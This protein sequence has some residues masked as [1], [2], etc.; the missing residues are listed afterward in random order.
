VLAGFRVRQDRRGMR[1]RCCAFSTVVFTVVVRGVVRL[2][3]SFA[4][5]VLFPGGRQEGSGEP[6]TGAVVFLGAGAVPGSPVRFRIGP[7]GCW[8]W[9]RAVV[10]LTSPS[11]LVEGVRNAEAARSGRVSAGSRGTETE[12]RRA[13]PRTRGRCAVRPVYGGCSGAVRREQRDARSFVLCNA[14]HRTNER[15]SGLAY[16]GSDP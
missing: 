16:G 3:R 12:T 13:A 14:L 15:A 5:R 2:P 6:G 1:G 4:R 9:S 7:P 11:C 8:S 10:F